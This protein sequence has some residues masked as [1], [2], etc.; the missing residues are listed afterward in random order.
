MPDIDT[1]LDDIETR[2]MRELDRVYTEMTRKLEGYIV[3]LDIQGGQFASTPLN[4]QRMA[5]AQREIAQIINDSGY[6]Q[7]TDNFISEY[8][9]II[10][11]LQR[12]YIA[13][14][15]N[16]GFTNVDRQAMRLATQFDIQRFESIGAQGAETVAKELLNAVAGNGNAVDFIASVRQSVPAYFKRWASTYAT[17]A[18]ANFNRLVEDKIQRE[19][20]I[21][22]FEY[23]GPMDKV[24]RPFC[25]GLL[26]TGDTHT[27]AEIAKMDN[28]QTAMGTVKEM[29]GGWNCRHRWLPAGI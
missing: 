10:D 5:N 21:T 28:G 29:G 25:A 3:S 22:E 14:G 27:R 9:D 15:I 17:T 8:A 11:Q 1:L 19:A 12:D 20:G 23:F 13:M 4:M 6:S 18:G 24:T 16:P 26:R 2:Y 7:I